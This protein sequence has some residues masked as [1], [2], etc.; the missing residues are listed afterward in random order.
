M[1]MKNKYL[2]AFILI[3]ALTGFY[4]GITHYIGYGAPVDNSPQASFHFNYNNTTN[5]VKIT[6]MGGDSISSSRILLLVNNK[7]IGNW[8]NLSEANEVT[9]GDSITIDSVSEGDQVQLIYK[10]P[11]KRHT[12]S[13][14][15]FAAGSGV[16]DRTFPG[17]RV[18][19][20]PPPPARDPAPP[21]NVSIR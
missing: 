11:N 12:L 19:L 4:F 17:T 10:S 2:V 1:V 20:P 21:R 16:R 5:I 14:Y 13:Y 9:R 3:M 15:T 7:S 6:H 18:G 8:D